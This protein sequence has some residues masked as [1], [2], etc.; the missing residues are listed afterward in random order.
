VTKPLKIDGAREKASMSDEDF[1]RHIADVRER[2]GLDR[3]EAMGGG[4]EQGR[5]KSSGLGQDRKGDAAMTNMNIGLTKHAKRKLMINTIELLRGWG[6]TLDDFIA[7][8]RKLEQ[9]TENTTKSP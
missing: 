3:R 7:E 8:W 2:I 4:S 6:I 5:T 9:Q 1:E